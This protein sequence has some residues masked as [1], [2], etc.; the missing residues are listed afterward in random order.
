VIIVKKHTITLLASLM[1]VIALSG[2]VGQTSGRG[3]TSGVIIK[4][5]GPDISEVFSG[6][7]VLFS[8]AVE[9]VGGEEATNVRG[10]LYGLGTDWSGPDWTGSRVK[11]VGTLERSQPEFD[12]PG[13]IGDA[14]WDV[15]APSGLKVDNEYTAGVRLYYGYSTTALVNLK[16][17]DND[18]LRSNPDIAEGIMRTSGIDSF[19]LTDAPI[20]IELAGVA[21]PL[22]YRSEVSGQQ[23][24]ITFLIENAGQGKPYRAEEDDMEVTVN[25]VTV[26]G[27]G[28]GGTGN[29]RLPRA[30]KKSVPCTF[31]LPSNIDT[32]TTIPAEMVIS[33]NY[34]IDST[35]SVTVLRSISTS[36]P[37]SS[38]SSN[39]PGGCP[40][41][42]TC[43][44]SEC[45]L[46]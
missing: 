36:G 4:S 17:Y 26:N 6:D 43:V 44:N 31:T 7:P 33:Y 13:G 18:Y 16:I 46:S 40:P 42:Y 10:K 28:C 25:T 11:T 15:Q 12:V 21:R 2:C 41:G 38:S 1:V 14:F 30:G 27:Q 23:A 34:F 9:N 37:S 20:R 3:T 5:F 39:C 29:Y 22:V 32:F 8:L 24:T 45:V 35:S 19:T